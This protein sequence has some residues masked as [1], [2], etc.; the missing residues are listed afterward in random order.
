MLWH[1]KYY[2]VYILIIVMHIQRHIPLS[3]YQQNNAFRG[4][5]IQKIKIVAVM[6]SQVHCN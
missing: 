4:F 3:T 5:L 2:S 6:N 1:A